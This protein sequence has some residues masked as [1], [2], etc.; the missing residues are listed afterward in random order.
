MRISGALLEALIKLLRSVGLLSDPEQEVQ[1][2][3]QLT[4]LEQTNAEVWVDFVKATVPDASRVYIWANSV[5]ALVRPA[6][7]TLIVGGMLFVPERILSLVKTFGEAGPSG[8]IVLAPV[9]W[10]F[11]GRDV[12]KV[13]AM[14]FGGILPVGSGAMELRPA[15]PARPGA[16]VPRW[17][18]SVPELEELDGDLGT[19]DT[20]DVELDRPR[21]R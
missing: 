9:L 20:P 17:D 16:P 4:D 1:F 19:I 3:R 15:E 6:I 21:D 2:R 13:L 5:I 12:N 7:S 14:R 11:F 10:W 8:W 18:W